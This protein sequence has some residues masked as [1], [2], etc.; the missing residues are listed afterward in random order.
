MVTAG[1]IVFIGATI[2]DRKMHAFDSRT[3]KLLWETTLPFAGHASPATYMIDGKQFVVIAAG[4]GRDPKWPSGGY[5]SPS[6]CRC[7]A[8][9]RGCA[10]RRNPARSVLLCSEND[11]V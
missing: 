2:F 3:G 1:G 9:P 6:R 7:T 4:G 8:T 5:M 10:M 11:L